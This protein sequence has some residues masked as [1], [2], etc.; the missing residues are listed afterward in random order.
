MCFHRV[1][2][3]HRYITGGVTYESMLSVRGKIC[4]SMKDAQKS[5]KK[6]DKKIARW[7]CTRCCIQLVYPWR[8]KGAWLHPLQPLHLK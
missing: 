4:E 6:V 7:G 3:L 8:L 2:N 5:V 1:Y